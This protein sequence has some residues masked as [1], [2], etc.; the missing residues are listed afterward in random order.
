MLS[1]LAT[2]PG[3]LEV[4]IDWPC[5]GLALDTTSWAEWA[6]I[7][8]SQAL[9]SLI[10]PLLSSGITYYYQRRTSIYLS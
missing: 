9:R 3:N 5:M 6:K 1:V 7:C 2:Q 10:P 8:F 4:I